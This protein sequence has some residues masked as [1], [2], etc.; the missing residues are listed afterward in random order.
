MGEAEGESL[1][2]LK[3]TQIEHVNLSSFPR[4]HQ[5]YV[6]E[7]VT[8]MRMKFYVKG[9]LRS[10]TVQLD[11]RKVRLTATLQL[12]QWVRA[13]SFSRRTNKESTS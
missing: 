7:G 11:M 2:E 6:V 10:G 5:E 1:C 9:S 12:G 4:R 8:Y 3:K 13:L